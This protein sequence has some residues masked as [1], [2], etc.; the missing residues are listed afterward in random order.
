MKIVDLKT[1]LSLP[2]G[3]VYANFTPNVCGR[4]SVKTSGPD[5]DGYFCYQSLGA[6]EI[7]STSSEELHDRIDDMVTNGTERPVVFDSSGRDG[8]INDDSL[9]AVLDDGD[10]ARLVEALTTKWRARG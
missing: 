4:L 10:V 6:L 3:T 7:D 1:F 9:Y 5:D 2:A 8:S